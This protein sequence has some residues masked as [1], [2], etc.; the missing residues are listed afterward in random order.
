MLACAP[1]PVVVAPP[2]SVVAEVPEDLLG[3]WRLSLDAEQRRHLDVLALALRDPA[4]SEDELDVLTADDATLVRAIVS[5]RRR[6]PADPEAARLEARRAALEQARLVFE[7]GR[8]TLGWPDATSAARWSV[9]SEAGDELVVETR[10]AS[11]EVERA[12]L[13]RLSRD[14]IAVR[15]DS[16]ARSL[17]FVRASR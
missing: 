12:R 2:L 9:V 7:P 3:V 4:P 1:E 13:T 8:I 16:S 11:G 14:T 17:V 15:S 10:S 6:N 5:A